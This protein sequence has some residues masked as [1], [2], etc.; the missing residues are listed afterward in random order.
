M[1]HIK[2]FEETYKGFYVHDLVIVDI[3]YSKGYYEKPVEKFLT[4]NV[5]EIISL[6]FSIAKIQYPSNELSDI[7]VKIDPYMNN[8]RDAEIF[9][10]IK[11]IYIMHLRHATEKEIEE[12]NLLKSTIKYNL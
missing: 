10:N 8:A 6:D 5:G 2:L 7:Y 9:N 3:E 4:S 1:K 12:Y 11:Q